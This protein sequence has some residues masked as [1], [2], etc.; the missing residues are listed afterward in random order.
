MPLMIHR[1]EDGQIYLLQVPETNCRLNPNLMKVVGESRVSQLLFGFAQRLKSCEIVVPQNQIHFSFSEQMWPFKDEIY[2]WIR[3]FKRIL[4]FELVKVDALGPGKK[5]MTD[6]QFREH[7]QVFQ[8]YTKKLGKP[9]MVRV[10]LF[11]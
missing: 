9:F 8:R 6:K 4:A 2:N 3:N 10:R 7:Y 1:R 5:G 11:Y